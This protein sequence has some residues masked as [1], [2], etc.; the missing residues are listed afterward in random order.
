MKAGAEPGL[1]PTRP[2]PCSRKSSARWA[3]RPLKIAAL[4]LFWAS[5]IFVGVGGPCHAQEAPVRT[6]ILVRHAAYDEAAPDNDHAS[7]TPLGIAQARLAANRLVTL[8]PPPM[9]L[10]ASTMTRALQTEA[11]IHERM[12]AVAEQ[13]SDLLRECMPRLSKDAKMV[14][15]SRSEAL[16]CEDQLNRAFATY[17]RPAA[18]DETDILVCHGNV[19]RYLVMKALGADTRLWLHFSIGNTSITE[20]QVRQ[21]GSMHILSV[22]D[23]GHLPPNMQSGTGQRTPDLVMSNG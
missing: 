11:I 21:D 17:F 22:G 5:A 7:L 10:I 20:I 8:A 12:L 18:K 14:A 4:R 15:P 23:I 13:R 2:P 6:I 1:G 3:R 19:I 9:E 16:A